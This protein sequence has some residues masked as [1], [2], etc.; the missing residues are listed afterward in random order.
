MRELSEVMKYAGEPG[1][2]LGTGGMKTKLHAAELCTAAGCD[3]VISNGAKP[4]LLYDIADGKDAG[5]RFLAPLK[6]QKN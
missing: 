2:S 5:T 1:S 4:M 3:M 6:R